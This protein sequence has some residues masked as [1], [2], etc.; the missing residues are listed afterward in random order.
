LTGNGLAGRLVDSHVHT[1]FSVD[2]RATMVEM[3]EQAIRLGLRELTF[4]EHLDLDPA[5][6]G[7]DYLRPDEYLAEIARCQQVYG[8]RIT[9]RAGLEVGDVQRFGDEIARR[10]ADL[11]LD[12]VIG[13]VHFI[14]GYFVGAADYLNSRD[15][16]AAI[17]DYFEQ[18]LLASAAGG[19]AVHGHLDV[20]KRRSTPMYG[21][22]QPEAWAEPIREALRRLIAGGRGIEINTSGVRTPAQ[23]PCPGLTILR[24][25]RELGGEILTL[26]SDSHRVEHL[27]YGLEVGA[28]LARTAGFTRICTFAQRQPIWHAL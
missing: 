24:W 4:T 8:D 27:G 3:V 7:C 21:P 1:T 26:G 17:G 14:D 28:E 19:F 25:Y 13:S 12:F 23:E 2:A 5:D 9:I 11:P 16:A 15:E 6:E 22:F 10:L 20:F 18:V